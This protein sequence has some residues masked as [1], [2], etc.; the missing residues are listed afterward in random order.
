MAYPG[1]M[2]MRALMAF[3]VAV[4]SYQAG[5]AQNTTVSGKIISPNTDSV[6]LQSNVRMDKG[7]KTLIHA[8]AKL[9]ENGEFLLKLALDSAQSLTFYDGLESTNLYLLP[10]DDVT[11]ELHTA[12]FDESLIFGGKGAARNNALAALSLTRSVNY[13]SCEQAR[14]NLDTTAL[15]KYMDKLK[16]KELLALSYYRTEFPEMKSY[17]K[18]LEDQVDASDK[19]Q[20]QSVRD[21]LALEQLVLKWRGAP[22]QD[23]LG[24]DLNGDSLRVSD[25]KGKITV[26]DFWATW[27]GPCKEEMPYL[28]QLETDY[29]EQVNFVSIAAWCKEDEWKPM[30]SKF[31]LE[32]NLFVSKEQMDQLEQYQITSI[33]R[34]MVLDAELKFLDIQAPRPSSGKLQLLFR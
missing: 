29:G 9:D 12:I 22:L 32:H 8:A 5:S 13:L 6:F 26:I 17:L 16:D 7:F 19:R 18:L 28:K 2:R 15:F 33:P 4:F 23:I 14:H 34:Y 1:S 3:C 24:V 30:A 25:F 27:C 10:G 11:M 31:G 21:D 20:K